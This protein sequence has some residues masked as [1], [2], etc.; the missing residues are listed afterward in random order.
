M[1]LDVYFLLKSSSQILTFKS[2]WWLVHTSQR[3]WMKTQEKAKLNIDISTQMEQFSTVVDLLGHGWGT[4]DGGGHMSPP[5]GHHPRLQA[6]TF[7]GSQRGDAWAQVLSWAH[8][9]V[10]PQALS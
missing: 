9:N 2:N 4:P 8:T 7:Q 6:H 1:N 10:C 3:F 5:D